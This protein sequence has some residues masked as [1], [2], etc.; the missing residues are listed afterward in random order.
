MPE[1]T[2]HYAGWL[3]GSESRNSR[4]AWGYTAGVSAQDMTA[5]KDW[6]QLLVWII[7]IAGVLGGLYKAAY[8][9]RENRK[10]RLAEL[11]WKRA[12]A[13]KRTS[14]RHSQG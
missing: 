1:A 6:V 4:W 5:V 9:I 10:Q 13:S 14:G 3:R 2:F 12:N 11:Q 8:E 7:G